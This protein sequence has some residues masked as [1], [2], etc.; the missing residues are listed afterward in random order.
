M[1][2]FFDR[3]P[4]ICLPYPNADFSR[5]DERCPYTRLITPSE[6]KDT[7]NQGTSKAPGE[8]GIIKEHLRHIPKI[9]LVWLAH[10]FSACL[11]LG[12]FPDNMKS[13]L[14]VF[15][16]K[17]GKPKCNPANYRPISL[18]SVVGKIFDKILTNRL[19]WFLED[20]NLQHPHQYGFR[21]GR[22]TVS[23]LAMSYEWI[24][25]QKARK[26]ARVTMVTRDIRGAFDFLPSKRLMFHLGVVGTP[27]LLLKCFCSFLRDR[28]ARVK[29]GSVIGPS[30]PLNAGTPQGAGPSAALFNLCVSK[31]PTPKT[32]HQYWSSYADDTS[33]LVCT[34]QKTASNDLHGIDVSKAVEVLNK[35]EHKEGLISEPLK[36]WIMPIGNIKPPYV[37]ADNHEYTMPPNCVGKLLG[38]QFRRSNMVGMQ[39]E[40]QAAKAR[41]S[42]STLWGFTR[43]KTRTKVHAIK[44]LVFPHLTYPVIPLHTATEAQMLKLQT[45]QNDAIRFAT[46][47]QWFDY[48]SCK[49]LH[50]DFRRKFQPVNQVLHHRAKK[51]WDKIREGSAGDIDQYNLLTKD[52]AP[53]SDEKYHKSFPSS[54]ELANLPEPLPLYTRRT[55]SQATRRR[56]RPIS[57]HVL[58]VRPRGARR[59]SSQRAGGRGR[60]HVRRGTPSQR[61]RGRGR[62]VVR[63]GLPAGSR[64]QTIGQRGRPIGRR[65]RPPRSARD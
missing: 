24:A 48:V 32:I 14:M 61:A 54:I 7:I 60:P 18:L 9:L 38:H 6:V 23:A 30:F 37:L 20:N 39:V 17:P 58:P 47:T 11:A 45:V 49:S 2:R 44:A 12:I 19:T 10:I 26:F 27:L 13:A 29:V 34:I 8:D 65:G 4:G 25:R 52:L 31:A 21:R 46:N 33:Q 28:T 3:N 50:N 40:S 59:I 53:K 63:R 22:G 36:S 35:F 5:L 55:P 62:P 43:A 42:L 1:E 15:I 64:G 41:A 51:V 56:G 57:R 16:H